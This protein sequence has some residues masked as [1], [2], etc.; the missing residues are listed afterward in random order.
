MLRHEKLQSHTQNAA[1]TSGSD[2]KARVTT[3]S[4]TCAAGQDWHFSRFVIRYTVIS[5]LAN[6]Q[7]RAGC[8]K[9]KH[10][11]ISPATSIKTEHNASIPQRAIRCDSKLTTVVPEDEGKEVETHRIILKLKG[12]SEGPHAHTRTP[13]PARW[14]DDVCLRRHGRSMEVFA[15]I[16]PTPP[17]LTS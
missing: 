5:A 9:S 13:I 1:I 14:W 12:Y 16:R 4:T 15:L 17:G 6:S 8:N 11:A 10:K 7:K 2:A 3:N